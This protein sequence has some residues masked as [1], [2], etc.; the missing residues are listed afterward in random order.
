MRPLNKQVTDANTKMAQQVAQVQGLEEQIETYQSEV[1]A[2]NKTKD[3]ANKKVESYDQL[4]KAAGT[5]LTGDQSSAAAQLAEVDGESMTGEGKKLYTSLNTLLQDYVF[6][7]AYNK[8]GT[9]YHGRRLCD[10][11]Y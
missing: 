4:L 6:N 11:Y 7:E 1:D 3:D 8:A 10:C 9:A 2:A 5:Y